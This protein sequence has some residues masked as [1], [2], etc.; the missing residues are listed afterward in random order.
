MLI[1]LGGLAEAHGEGFEWGEK[2]R[3]VVALARKAV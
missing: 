2:V 3:G 1:I